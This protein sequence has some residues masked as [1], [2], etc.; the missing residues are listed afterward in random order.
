MPA[1][2]AELGNAHPTRSW[3]ADQSERWPI[4]RLIP[5]A[6]NARVHTEA[7]LAK[8]PESLSREEVETSH[9]RIVQALLTREY[10]PRWAHERWAL[11]R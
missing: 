3:P 10:R 4:E 1:I 9:A 6:N 5:Y 2:Q 8:Q 7:D 11:I